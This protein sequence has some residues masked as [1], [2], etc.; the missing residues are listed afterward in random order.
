[1]RV[2]ELISALQKLQDQLGDKRVF[3]HEWD[4][5]DG[6]VLK[7]LRDGAIQP[8]AYKVGDDTGFYGI[9]IGN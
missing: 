1:M 6:I 8:I 7:E 9:G 2:S 4:D 3:T 5:E